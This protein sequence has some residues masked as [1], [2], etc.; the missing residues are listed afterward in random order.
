MK[1]IRPL[2]LARLFLLLGLLPLAAQA[3]CDGAFCSLSTDW[4]IQ[5]VASKLGLR[6]DIRAECIDLDQLR[7]GTH[8]VAQSGVVDTKDEVRIINRNLL[9]TLDWNINADWGMTLKCHLL[10]VR[11]IIFLIKTMAL[12]V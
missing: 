5:G 7:R 1:V 10:A 12:A 3:S 4:D 8:K 11:A 6:L 2:A 9:A